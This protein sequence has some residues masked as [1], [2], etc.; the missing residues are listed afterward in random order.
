[1]FIGLQRLDLPH[2]FFTIVRC[3]SFGL[4]H[5]T[6]AGNDFTP[7]LLYFLLQSSN[8]TFIMN[9]WRPALNPG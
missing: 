4:C 9:L 2:H 6:V 1:M 5:L 7:Q 8:Q 3:Y